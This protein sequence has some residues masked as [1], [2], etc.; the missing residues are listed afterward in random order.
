LTKERVESYVA[1]HPDALNA[2]EGWLES[3]GFNLE[4]D[5]THSDAKDWINLSVPVRMAEQLL[6][7]TYSVFKHDSGESIVRT[8]YYNLPAHLH[9]HI[10]VIQPTTNFGLF[11]SMKAT[12]FFEEE[13]VSLVSNNDR[14]LASTNAI[15]NASCNTTITPQCLYQLYD[16]NYNGSSKTGNSIATTGYLEQY[17][18]FTD[19]NAFYKAY[20]PAAVNSPVTIY[21]V[22]GGINNQSQPGGEAELDTQYAYGLAYPAKNIFYSTAGRPPFNPDNFTTSDTNEPYQEWLDFI[23]SQKQKDIPLIVSTSYGDDEQTVPQSYAKRV[24]SGFA[25]LGARGVSVLFSSGDYGVG[26]GETDP[27]QVGSQTHVVTA[28]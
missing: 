12:H 13:E 27:A 18:N 2:V 10:D 1:P 3:H 20:V 15:V 21:N 17:F 7:T 14:V 8:T 24:C 23:L 6:N 9:G 5:I 28:S 16:I 22:A 11:K 25:Q 19:L 4:Q 26:D